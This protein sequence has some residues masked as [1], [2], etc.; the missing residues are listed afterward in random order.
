MQTV[1]FKGVEPQSVIVAG[2]NLSFL[3][4]GVNVSL[5]LSRLLMNKETLG[6]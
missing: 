6:G 5:F 4:V 2:E 1:R 3:N